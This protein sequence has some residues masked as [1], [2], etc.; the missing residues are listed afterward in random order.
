MKS[1]PFNVGNYWINERP[2]YIYLDNIK[3]IANEYYKYA[4]YKNIPKWFMNTPFVKIIQMVNTESLIN[5]PDFNE[6]IWSV[7]IPTDKMQY[8][9]LNNDKDV[10][11]LPAVSMCMTT[12][13]DAGERGMLE[14]KQYRKFLDIIEQKGYRPFGII[15]SEMFIRCWNNNNYQRFLEVKIPI[16]ENFQ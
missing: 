10:K 4:D 7:A 13:L 8:I 12:V 16:R 9:G 14:L 3:R 2:E 15:T 5:N 6:D 11:S 1:L